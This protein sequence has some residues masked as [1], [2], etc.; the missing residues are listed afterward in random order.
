MATCFGPFLDHPQATHL[1][2]R[3]THYV[4]LQYL[5]FKNFYKCFYA[6]SFNSMGSHNVYC[7]L[8]VPFKDKCWPEGGLGKDRNM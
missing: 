3:T 2:V 6:H 1:S 4:I 8:V 7:A 5:N